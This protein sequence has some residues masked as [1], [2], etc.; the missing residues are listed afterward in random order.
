M[1]IKIDAINLI[2]RKLEGQRRQ[3][4]LRW[5]K[6]YR[7]TGDQLL[8][9]MEKL[10]KLPDT[11]ALHSNTLHGFAK[12]ANVRAA[13]RRGDLIKDICKEHGVSHETLYRFVADLP[14]RRTRD[15]HGDE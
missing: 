7:T 15:D 12:R 2:E 10:E 14:K 1:S 4:A 9:F 8:S 11:G 13:Y 5:A 3:D 6:S